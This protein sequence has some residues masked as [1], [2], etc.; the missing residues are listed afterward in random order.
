MRD[1]K[2]PMVSVVIPAYNRK[3]W[4]EFAIKS[5]LNQTYHSYEIIVIDDGSSENLYE[6]KIMKNKKIKYFR[7]ENHG[8]AYSR[9]FG[10]RKSSGKYVAFLDSDDFWDKMKLEYQVE[11]MEKNQLKWSQHNYYY[12]NE[13]GT[14]KIKQIDTYKY[15]FAPNKF[16][17]TSFKVQT[18]CFM[19]DRE[20]VLK[21]D[22]KFDEKKT[23][24][25]DNEFYYQMLKKT[26]LGFINR[27][28]TFFRVKNS[29]AGKNALKQLSNRA[30][31]Y[32]E[33]S[34]DNYFL[35]NTDSISK[36]AYRISCFFDKFSKRYNFNKHMIKI[37]YFF[38]WILFQMD[39]FLLLLLYGVKHEKCQ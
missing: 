6:M 10:M 12:V 34:K 32:S 23:Y 30:M 20:F 3:E 35:D 21:N 36:T 28:L 9:N 38:P 25:E 29:N 7:N 5:V 1:D 26:P 14:E 33:H 17:F 27:Y 39:T 2:A 31:T 22:F 13:D 4:L 24:G 18:S 19:V 37:V 15:R 11:F 16:Q 8:V